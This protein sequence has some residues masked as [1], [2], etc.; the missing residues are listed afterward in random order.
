MP[1]DLFQKFPKFG[2]IKFGPLK[3]TSSANIGNI[4]HFYDF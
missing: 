3:Y 4:A 2:K 1:D